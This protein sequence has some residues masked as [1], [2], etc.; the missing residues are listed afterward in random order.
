MSDVVITD[1]EGVCC[2]AINR[3]ES[4][5]GLTDS[6]NARIIEALQG[7][8]ALPAVRCVVITGT[9][10][11]FCSGLDLK[12]LAAGGMGSLDSAEEH[13]QRYFHGMIRAV[14]ALPKPVIALVDGAAVG[15]GCDL[16]L[17]CDLRIGTE[18]TRF[19][20]VFVKRGL[21]PDG[22]GTWSLPRLVGVGKALELMFT[23]D[24]VD[25]A[26]AERLGLLN[27]VVASAEALAQ[28]LELAK[29]I[30]AGPP[31]VHAWIKRA[32]YD[33]QSTSLDEALDVEARGQMQL[34]HSKDFLEG[35]S[36]FFQKRAPNFTGE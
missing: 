24:L 4:K 16:A 31:L 12:A 18:R 17:A 5:N 11:N 8:A 3:P 28:T 15:Y 35:I 2:I 23:G 27:R 13:L 14:R 32:V 36:A 30:A 22:G 29:R 26:T 1:D 10:G 34:L 7:A 6:V 21:M 25:A 20:E 19:G 9:G 33:A